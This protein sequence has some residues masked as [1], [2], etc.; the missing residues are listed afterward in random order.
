MWVIRRSNDRAGWY[1]EHGLAHLLPACEAPLFRVLANGQNS[2]R[3]PLPRLERP[4]SVP[5][6]LLPL[7]EAGAP[8]SWQPWEV[9]L[10][11]W[12]WQDVVLAHHLPSWCIKEFI[13]FFIF[14]NGNL[15]VTPL[16]ISL[17]VAY[18]WKGEFLNS[19]LFFLP[20]KPMFKSHRET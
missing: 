20:W 18:P 1:F 11:A 9:P 6:V 4:D 14:I 17:S 2:G 15:W 12:Q 7:S 19:F 8:L 16:K 3:A 10:S 5:G 13:Y